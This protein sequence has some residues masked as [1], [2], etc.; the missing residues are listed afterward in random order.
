MLYCCKVSMTH[1]NAIVLLD[2]LTT[3]HQLFVTIGILFSGLV[4]YV[5]VPTAS[6]DGS[7]G[8]CLAA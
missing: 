6:V 5:Y 4:G 1:L 7:T 8:P 2:R 3:M